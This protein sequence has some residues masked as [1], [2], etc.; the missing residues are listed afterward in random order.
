MRD[1][2]ARA[3]L[4]AG[5]YVRGENGEAADQDRKLDRAARK[6]TGRDGLTAEKSSLTST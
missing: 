4:L 6:R 2:L 3:S 1:K 5:G